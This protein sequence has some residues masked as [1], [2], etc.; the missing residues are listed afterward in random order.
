M[1]KAVCLGVG[2]E[3]GVHPK[4]KRRTERSP[5][6]AFIGG[7]HWGTLRTVENTG[8]L[9]KLGHTA[10]HSAGGEYTPLAPWRP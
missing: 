3:D 4:V 8:E 1:G 10:D 7:V 9:I 6:R 5:H 2:C